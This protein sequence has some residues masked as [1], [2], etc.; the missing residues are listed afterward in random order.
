MIIRDEQMNSE[1]E[2]ADIVSALSLPDPPLCR[3]SPGKNQGHQN[4]DH[5]DDHQEFDEAEG[6]LR[7]LAAFT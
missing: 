3:N 4:G 7:V 6:A 2:L 1:S 5:R